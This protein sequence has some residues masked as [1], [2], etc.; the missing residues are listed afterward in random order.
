MGERGVIE[1]QR[2]D[3]KVGTGMLVDDLPGSREYP[4]LTCSFLKTSQRGQVDFL[5]G[6]DNV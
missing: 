3:Y 4:A 5:S 6:I 2:E 1:A